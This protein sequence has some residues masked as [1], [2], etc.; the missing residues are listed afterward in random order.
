MVLPSG[1][2]LEGFKILRGIPTAGGSSAGVPHA[3]FPLGSTEQFEA[4]LVGSSRVMH[5]RRT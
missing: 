1:K 2:N 4:P 5:V 3:S